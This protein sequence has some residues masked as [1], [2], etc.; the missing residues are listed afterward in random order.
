MTLG[1]DGP[2]GVNRT[3]GAGADPEEDWKAHSL[4]CAARKL[5]REDGNRVCIAL[6]GVEI[7]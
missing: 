7:L 1:G 6:A 3:R 4:E 2:R 5:L